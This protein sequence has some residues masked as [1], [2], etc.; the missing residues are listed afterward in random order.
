MLVFLVVLWFNG[1]LIISIIVWVALQA[2]VTACV[3]KHD[4]GYWNFFKDC[5]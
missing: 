3:W 4:F 5:F 1:S 2:I